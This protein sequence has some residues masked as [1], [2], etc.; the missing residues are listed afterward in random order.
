MSSRVDI[1]KCKR[2]GQLYAPIFKSYEPQKILD[3]VEK[4]GLYISSVDTYY[5]VED[6][7]GFAKNTVKKEVAP[8]ILE[9]FIFLEGVNGGKKCIYK[10]LPNKQQLFSRC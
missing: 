2:C 6:L 9:K 5:D 4:K 1:Y 3:E 10:V 8:G 7:D